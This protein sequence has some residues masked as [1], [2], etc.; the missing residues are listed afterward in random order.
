MISHT[1][2]EQQAPL[3]IRVL[4]GAGIG[5]LAGLLLIG[6]GLLR[7]LVHL[8]G[9]GRLQALSMSDLRTFVFYVGGFALG[10][11]VFGALRP[12]LRGTRGIYVGCMIAGAIV[13]L[14]LAVS[15]V[16]PGEA[17]GLMYW[18]VL[19]IAGAI[20]GAAVAFGWTRARGMLGQE[21]P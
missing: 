19:I 16:K 17:L 14:A 6:V 18:L 12:A 9:G 11:A 7:A 20:F 3:A 15:D 5:A 10:G 2:S 8:L 21:G 4:A 13:M 1:P